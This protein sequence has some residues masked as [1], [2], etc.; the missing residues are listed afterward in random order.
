MES[1]LFCCC[2]CF[3]LSSEL[4]SGGEDEEVAAVISV[5]IAAAA[6]SELKEERQDSKEATLP[7]K[8]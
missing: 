2:S 8:N 7:L 1:F 5:E 6:T 4:W 3:N